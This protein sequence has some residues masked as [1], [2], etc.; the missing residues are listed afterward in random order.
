MIKSITR[1]LYIDGKLI[2]DPPQKKSH[3]KQILHKRLIISCFYSHFAQKN[4][5]KLGILGSFF[6]FFILRGTK[7]MIR[8]PRLLIS[9]KYNTNPAKWQHLI[10]YPSFVNQSIAQCGAISD[11]H[12]RINQTVKQASRASVRAFSS[13]CWPMKTSFCMRSP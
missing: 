11:I 12:R 5:I 10:H 3:L 1:T 4:S 9:D 2:I 8:K 13:M 7:A 6:L